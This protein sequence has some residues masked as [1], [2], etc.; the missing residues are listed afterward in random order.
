MLPSLMYGVTLGQVDNFEDGTTQNWVINLLN[1]GSPPP[2]AFPKNVPT[3]GPS[4]LN[5]NYLQLTST[6]SDGPGGRLVGVQYQNQWAG[7]FLAAGI[8]GISM[9][10][11]NLGGTDLYLRLLI[12]DPMDAP[13]ENEA[14][15]TTAV[16][17]PVG[18]GWRSVLFPIAPGFLTADVGT[19]TAALTNATE[20]R[21]FSAEALGPPSR[22]AGSLGV[23]NITASQVPEPATS[24]L[25][26]IGTACLATLRSRFHQV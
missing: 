20:F 26:V 8:S 3:G 13:P 23:D 24:L 14:I 4:G 10:V 21:I 12:A 7:N 17:L 19:V 11:N 22:I 25:V 9:N 1:M 2:E 16:F 5:D 6:G 15:S 18:S